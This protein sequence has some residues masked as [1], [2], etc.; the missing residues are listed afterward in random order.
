LVKAYDGLEQ[1]ELEKYLTVNEFVTRFG[2]SK[3]EFSTQAKW[4]RVAKKKALLLF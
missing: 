3:E 1:T 4:R 2:C